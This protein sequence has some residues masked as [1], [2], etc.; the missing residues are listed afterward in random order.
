MVA[1]YVGYGDVEKQ[2]ESDPESNYVERYALTTTGEPVGLTEY[3]QRIALSPST[4]VILIME[5]HH[6][7]AKP[8]LPWHIHP[9]ERECF[10]ELELPKRYG[11]LRV[12]YDPYSDAIK[13]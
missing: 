6:R 12:T 10:R 13:L 7:K 4:H 1:K 5:A 9:K 8:I 2:P 3:A 11:K